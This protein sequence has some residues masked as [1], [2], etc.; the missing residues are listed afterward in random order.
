LLIDEEII[1]CPKCKGKCW[2]RTA[3]VVG[4]GEANH[5]FSRTIQECTNC[6]HCSDEIEDHG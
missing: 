5:S 1:E 6:N 4:I 3:W 2:E